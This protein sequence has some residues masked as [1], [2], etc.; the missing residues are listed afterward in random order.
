MNV[1]NFQLSNIF[2]QN[3]KKYVTKPVMAAIY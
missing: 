1:D 3:A 2:Q